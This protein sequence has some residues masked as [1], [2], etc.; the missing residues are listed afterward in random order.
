GTAPEVR[1]GPATSRGPA[2]RQART[3]QPAPSSAA[4]TKATPAPALPARRSN[5]R[6]LEKVIISYAGPVVD[7]SDC[8]LRIRSVAALAEC[9]DNSRDAAHG[10]RTRRWTMSGDRRRARLKGGAGRIQID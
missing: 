4:P 2:Q 1:P 3:A 8:G 6:S 5:Q 10:T 7:R 9:R